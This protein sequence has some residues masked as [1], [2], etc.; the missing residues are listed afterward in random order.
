MYQA[1]AKSRTASEFFSITS[2]DFRRR[3][4][5]QY[6]SR[7]LKRS[8]PRRSRLANA[9]KLPPNKA[10]WT[11][12]PLGSDRHRSCRTS[13]STS[14]SAASRRR[15][16]AYR[17]ELTRLEPTCSGS[18]PRIERD[19]SR[20]VEASD[21]GLS[22]QSTAPRPVDQRFRLFCN[23]GIDRS[24]HSKCQGI[25]DEV[26]QIM[27]RRSNQAYSALSLWNNEQAEKCESNQMK[28]FTTFLYRLKPPRQNPASKVNLKY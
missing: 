19:F 4:P 27:I 12:I 8:C 14:G 18:S 25:D 10:P 28:P 23:P 22:T 21:T 3:S 6:E 5:I 1:L 20:C 7:W 24:T 11:S 16:L 17:S 2:P 13:D 9:P 15:A 26:C